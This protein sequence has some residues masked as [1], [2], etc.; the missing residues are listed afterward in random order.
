MLFNF[1]LKYILHACLSPDT[2]VCVLSRNLSWRC[3][4]EMVLVCW[5]IELNSPETEKN[6]PSVSGLSLQWPASPQANNVRLGSGGEFH[7]L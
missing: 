1:S 3:L 4:E 5:R 7:S 6:S 2:S